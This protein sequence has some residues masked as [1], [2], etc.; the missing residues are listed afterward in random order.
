MLTETLS[1]KCPCCGYDKLLQRY[2][3]YG[4]YQLDGCPKCGFG[5][6]TNHHDGDTFGTEAWIDYARHVLASSESDN[7]LSEFEDD[8][9]VVRT[10]NGYTNNGGKTKEYKAYEKAISV[11]YSYPDSKIRE[12]IFEWAES[13]ERYD[14]VEYTVFEYDEKAV[15]DYLKTNP[16][17]F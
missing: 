13:Q 17:I 7:Y 10:E 6:G 9:E 16:I 2:G 4:H 8:P 3:S 14:D 1:G 15:E 11:L 5:Y 12:M